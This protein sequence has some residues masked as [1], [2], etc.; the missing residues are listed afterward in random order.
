MNNDERTR[1][2]N[3]LRMM[4]E[5]GKLADGDYANL[6]AALRIGDQAYSKAKVAAGVASAPFAKAKNPAKPR[7]PKSLPLAI[8]LNFLLAGAGYWYLGDI[9]RGVLALFVALLM[10]VGLSAMSAI[11]AAVLAP[12]IWFGLMLAFSVDMY[13][14]H[15]RNCMKQCPQCAEMVQAAAVVCRYCGADVA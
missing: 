12:S 13:F 4:R 2:I 14:I 7:K 8:A 9:Y 3:K 6:I 10:L 11:E 5:R 1:E 15:R